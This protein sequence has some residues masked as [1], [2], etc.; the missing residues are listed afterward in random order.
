MTTPKLNTAAK[1][2]LISLLK[3]A[4]AQA[5]TG[6]FP[7]DTDQ[8]LNICEYE[9]ITPLVWHQI[10]ANN[11]QTSLPPPLT[12]K[13]QALSLQYAAINM[14]RQQELQRLIKLL[15]SEG[16]DF[17]LLK[18]E[19]LAVTCYPQ[20]YLRTRT[21]SDLLFSSKEA[22]EKAWQLLKLEGYNRLATLQGEFV[23][24]Q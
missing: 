5:D 13:L 10:T 2:W 11:L 16:L 15:R 24:F 6:Q 4:E 3:G 22:S 19:A 1:D 17:L 9:G 23:G 20:A 7:F 12:A 8:L 21:D 14:L 18:G